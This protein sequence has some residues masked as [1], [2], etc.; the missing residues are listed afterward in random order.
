MAEE[1]SKLVTTGDGD[2]VRLPSSSAEMLKESAQAHTPTA[3]E[4]RK[5]AT[6]VAEGQA[7]SEARE[8]REAPSA[9]ISSRTQQGPD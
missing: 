3:A 1:S 8:K 4:L 9:S 2:V 7:L 5:A 6:S